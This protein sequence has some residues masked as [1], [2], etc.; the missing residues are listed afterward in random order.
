MTPDIKQPILSSPHSHPDL[1][2]VVDDKSNNRLLFQT[3]LSSAGYEVRAAKTGEEALAC[4]QEERPPSAVVLDVLLPKLNGYEVCRR[5][6]SMEQARFVPVILVTALHGEEERMRGIEAG[7]DDFIGRPFN[8]LELLIRIKSLMRI[9]QLHDALEQ[10]VVELEKAKG[11]LAQ[12]AV[13]DGLTGVYN[14]QYFKHKLQQ[15]IARSK[16]NGLPVSLLMMDID[17]FKSINDRFGHQ[18]GDRI[19]KRFSVL[20]R[21]NIRQTDLLA[22]YG[23]EEFVVVLPDTDKESARW[24]AEKLR[25]LVEKSCT[26]I[27]KLPQGAI[28]ISV[29]VAAHPADA[30]TI[31]DLIRLSDQA[32][33]RAKGEG[34]NRT[35]LA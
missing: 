30:L 13:T 8:R 23:G 22:R 26:T 2:L 9:K 32:L 21:E 11:Q 3:Y 14:Y 34:R 1:V 24:V 6:K 35:I 31:D 12:L 29:G 18:Q 15:E 7:A 25:M 28:T 4:F 19:L 20:L 33:Y 10:K 17:R 27:E 5:I 16:R